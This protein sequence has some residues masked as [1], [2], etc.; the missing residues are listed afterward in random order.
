M[1]KE[2]K[3]D[4]TEIQKIVRDYKHAKKRTTQN[5]WTNS[6]KG[7]KTELERNRKVPRLNQKE[8]ENISRP[9][10]SAET[11]SVIRKLPTNKSLGPDGLTD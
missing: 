1:K 7:T 4:L 6:Q 3:V 9:N 10:T 8:I 11:E 2:V 5:K